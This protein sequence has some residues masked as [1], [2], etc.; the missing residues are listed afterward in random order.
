MPV[1]HIQMIEG[2]SVEQKRQLAEAIT[3]A[4]VDIAKTAP[5]AV[6]IVIDDYPRTNWAKAGKLMSEQ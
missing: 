3:R 1:V 4:L 5:E 2:R 6:N